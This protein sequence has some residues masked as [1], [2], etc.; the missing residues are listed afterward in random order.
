MYFCPQ[1]E[2]FSFL[3]LEIRTMFNVTKENNI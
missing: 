1:T 3:N 2:Q